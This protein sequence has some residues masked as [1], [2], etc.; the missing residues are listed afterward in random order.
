MKMVSSKPNVHAA[1]VEALTSAVLGECGATDPSTRDAA[2]H[3]GSLPPSL[4]AFVEQVR[5][6]SATIADSDIARLRT[7]GYS[8]DDIFEI[9]IAAALGAAVR[10]LDAGLRAMAPE[11]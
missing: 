3:A 6:D 1:E 5:H 4:E 2:F 7:N 9:T 10:R 8:D 11:V